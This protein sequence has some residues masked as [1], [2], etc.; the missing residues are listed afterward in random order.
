[1]NICD[2][3]DTVNKA[4]TNSNITGEKPYEAMT[5]YNSENYIKF[6]AE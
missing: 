1:M 5:G 3:E 6:D 4:R 2:D